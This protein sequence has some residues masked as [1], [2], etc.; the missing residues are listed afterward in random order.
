MF[1]EILNCEKE[2][3]RL[4]YSDGVMLK[5]KPSASLCMM[6]GL[7]PPSSSDTFFRLELAA[8]VMMM[9]PTWNQK[10]HVDKLYHFKSTIVCCITVLVILIPHSK[11][12]STVKEPQKIQNRDR[13]KE[14]CYIQQTD[15]SSTMLYIL[16]QSLS[17]IITVRFLFVSCMT[18]KEHK[19]KNK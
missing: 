10:G 12:Q 18:S 16:F 1:T 4:W 9:R 19:E 7:F 13:Y 5:Y 14:F 3:F 15:D 2:V 8:S 11:I 17:K 6:R